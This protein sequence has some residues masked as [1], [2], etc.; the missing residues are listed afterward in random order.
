MEEMHVKV[1]TLAER[2]RQIVQN[3]PIWHGILIFNRR[4]ENDRSKL[5]TNKNRQKNESI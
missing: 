2:V 5:D 3:S 4:Y 1:S